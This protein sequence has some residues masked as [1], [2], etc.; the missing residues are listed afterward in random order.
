[1]ASIIL[2]N[3]LRIQWIWKFDEDEMCTTKANLVPMKSGMPLNKLLTGY[4][5]CANYQ[6]IYH[7]WPWSSD[8]YIDLRWRRQIQYF[9]SAIAHRSLR[10]HCTIEACSSFRRWNTTELDLTLDLRQPERLIFLEWCSWILF[11]F[12]GLCCNSTDSIQSI[13]IRTQGMND[14]HKTT[15]DICHLFCRFHSRTWMRFGVSSHRPKT[16][17]LIDLPE[18]LKID[19]SIPLSLIGVV[20][21]RRIEWETATWDT[22]LL[23]CIL[24]WCCLTTLTSPVFSGQDKL[25]MLLWMHQLTLLQEY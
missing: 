10:E 13:Q 8:Q 9:D 7:E 12:A 18:R 19:N 24:E 15:V 17:S 2:I 3:S 21:L 23:A 14:R 6:R 5:K 1:M 22:N 25:Q 16:S 4:T 11:R 20:R